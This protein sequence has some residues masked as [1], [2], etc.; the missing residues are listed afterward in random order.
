MTTPN[1]WDS[2][3]TSLQGR[4]DDDRKITFEPSFNHEIGIRVGNQVPVWVDALDLLRVV[5]HA[6][7]NITYGPSPTETDRV[8]TTPP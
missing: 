7:L 3:E 2:P 4:Y 5:S 8:V 1:P 6:A